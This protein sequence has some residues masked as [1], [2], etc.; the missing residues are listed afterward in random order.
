MHA[1]SRR[2]RFLSGPFPFFLFA[3]DSAADAQLPLASPLLAAP[4]DVVD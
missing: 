2:S 4:R 3:D 1:A